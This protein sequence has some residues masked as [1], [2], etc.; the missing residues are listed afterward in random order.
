MTLRIKPVVNSYPLCVAAFY[1]YMLK[2]WHFRFM[3]VID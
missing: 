2:S 3:F 1:I